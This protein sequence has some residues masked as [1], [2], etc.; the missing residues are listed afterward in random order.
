MQKNNL[1][2]MLYLNFIILGTFPLIMYFFSGL[3]LNSMLEDVYGYKD[4][5][6][7]SAVAHRFSQY[8]IITDEVIRGFVKKAVVNSISFEINDLKGQEESAKSYF[9]SIGWKSFWG[10][11]K[12]NQESLIKNDGV[13]RII[14]VINQDP[15]IIGF[16]EA[17]GKKYWK[18]YLDGNYQSIGKGGSVNNPFKAILE[19]SQTSSSEN[20]RG[21]AIDRMDIR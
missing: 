5:T 7:S 11:Y 8:P 9:S 15:L 19:L 18:F 2:K 16:R 12:T 10:S 21:I 14:A 4:D 3:G 1:K 6:M 17:R 20:I 13:I